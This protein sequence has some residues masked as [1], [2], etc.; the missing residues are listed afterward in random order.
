M[1][2]SSISVNFHEKIVEAVNKGFFPLPL[3]I[4]EKCCLFLA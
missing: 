1:N 4:D 3:E 2:K